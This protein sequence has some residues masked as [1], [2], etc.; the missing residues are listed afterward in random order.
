MH[1][2]TIAARLPG[3]SKVI[4]CKVRFPRHLSSCAVAYVF[5]GL[6][7]KVLHPRIACA[8]YAPRDPVPRHVY[9]TPSRPS[10]A[11]HLYAITNGCSTGPR[12]FAD[13]PPPP[14]QRRRQVRASLT[15]VP[16]ANHV[17]Y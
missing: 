1:E 4:V 9:G 7:G 16:V 17:T 15:S 2:C 3:S 8:V 10:N 12:M 13:P 6:S 11:S 14:N 5:T